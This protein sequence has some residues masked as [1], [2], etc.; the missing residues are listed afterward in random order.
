MNNNQKRLIF[1]FVIT[2]LVLTALF[3]LLTKTS[4]AITSYCF[5][6]LA[7]IMFF[8]TIW[9]VA[10]GSKNKYITNAA[11]PIQACSYCVLNLIVCGIFVILD[12][13]CIW[14]IPVGWFAFIH[15]ILIAFFAWRVLA[16]DA[17]QEEIEK[18]GKNVQLKTTN[19]RMIGADVEFLKNNAPEICP[20]EL[21]DVIDAIRY[22]DPMT[23]PELELLDEAI[24]DSV[25]QLELN[26]KEQK[27]EDVSLICLKIQ[28]QIKD[29]NT[30]AKILK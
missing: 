7:P 6:L 29:R 4:L 9:L 21:Q 19:W 3:L 26:F 27:I 25:L 23:C 1:G 18:V 8:G 11:F 12:Q 28:K 22:A 14:S 5:S 17:G 24:K 20:K 16:M 10:S 2:I 30:R 13:T 15:I